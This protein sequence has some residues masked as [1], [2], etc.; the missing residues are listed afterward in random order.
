MLIY[1]NVSKDSKI[2]TSDKPKNNVFI[3]KCFGEKN[4]SVERFFASSTRADRDDW[5]QKIQEASR[6]LDGQI[7]VAKKIKE[8]QKLE[9]SI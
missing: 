3:L 2:L 4:S 9:K 7:S 8:N 6:D 5:I 1:K